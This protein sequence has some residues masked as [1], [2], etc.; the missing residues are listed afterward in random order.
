MVDVSASIA[1]LPDKTLLLLDDDAPLRTRLGR[2]LESRGFETELVY[3]VTDRL[4]VRLNGMVG[5][6]ELARVDPGFATR[7]DIGLP[8]VPDL[9]G[10]ASIAYSRPLGRGWTVLVDGQIQY[11]GAS[12]LTFDPSLSPRMGDYTL[13]KASAALVGPRWRLTAVL[14]NPSDSSGDT[15]AYGN[16]FSLRSARQVTPLRPLTFSLSLGLTF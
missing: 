15:F 14:G 12:R 13:A 1:E 2:A 7:R 11:V 5:E 4:S 3:R 9:S 6:P 16:P 10:G 8:G